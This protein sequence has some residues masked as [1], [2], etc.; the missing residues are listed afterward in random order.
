[1]KFLLAASGSQFRRSWKA[2]ELVHCFSIELGA[3]VEMEK[4]IIHRLSCT[5]IGSSSGAKGNDWDLLS[6]EIL[7]GIDA[8][9]TG[10]IWIQCSQDLPI[11]LACVRGLNNTAD[12]NRSDKDS[13][14]SFCVK[15]SSVLRESCC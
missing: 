2:P 6:E 8:W 4:P 9:S 5:S 1:M 7:I 10:Y 14:S 13:A 11:G 15:G 12:T 3:V